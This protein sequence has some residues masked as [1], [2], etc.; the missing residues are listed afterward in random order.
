MACS[1]VNFTLPIAPIIRTGPVFCVVVLADVTEQVTSKF[2]QGGL[3]CQDSKL[4]HLRLS[5]TL[6]M[7]F[8]RNSLSFAS[9]ASISLR[10]LTMLLYASDCE[11]K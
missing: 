7:L 8:S 9:N 4:Q 3:T 10:R 2:G 1:M 5:V 11:R 6:A